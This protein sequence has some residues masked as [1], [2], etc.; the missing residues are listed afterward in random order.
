[1]IKLS[2]EEQTLVTGHKPDVASFTE[3]LS[4]ATQPFL[5]P[6]DHGS[7]HLS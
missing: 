1:M 3:A 4:F 5:N 6:V 7:A 2:L